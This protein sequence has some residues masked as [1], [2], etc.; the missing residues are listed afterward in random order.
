MTNSSPV[1]II[2]LAKLL[3]RANGGIV[4]VSQLYKEAKDFGSLAS[5]PTPSV[6]DLVTAC[7]NNGLTTKDLRRTIRKGNRKRKRGMSSMNS[8]LGR[9]SHAVPAAR[10]VT[11]QNPPDRV[12]SPTLL[13]SDDEGAL[14]HLPPTMRYLPPHFPPLPPRHTYLRTPVGFLQRISLRD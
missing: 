12:P 13:P 1:R 5:R 14:P 4:D 2:I 3:R 8:G 6:A 9:V 11:L 10:P 7:S